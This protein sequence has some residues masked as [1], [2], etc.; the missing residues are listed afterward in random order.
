MFF[1]DNTSIS[2]LQCVT[3]KVRSDGAVHYYGTTS[4]SGS[5]STTF[6]RYVVPRRSYG[7]LPPTQLQLF[8]CLMQYHFG[9]A[10]TTRPTLCTG[11][12]WEMV[13]SFKAITV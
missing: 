13:S 12:F 7:I 11:N 5:L 8:A 10:Y 3:V 9:Q 4:V 6:T 1:F 2:I